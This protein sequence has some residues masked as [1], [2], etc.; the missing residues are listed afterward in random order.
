MGHH[1][2][3]KILL[4]LDSTLPISGEDGSPYFEKVTFVVG[5]HAD[6]RSY[7][8]NNQSRPMIAHTKSCP[9]DKIIKCHPTTWGNLT[10]KQ[11]RS[12]FC[13]NP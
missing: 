10:K 7:P 1:V 5:T 11:Q 13:I 2:M 9:N 12:F 4:Q 8:V 6:M 3:P